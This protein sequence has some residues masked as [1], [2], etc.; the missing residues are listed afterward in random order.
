MN[1]FVARGSRWLAAALL[2]AI[3]PVHAESLGAGTLTPASGALTFDVLN[4][5]V[6]LKPGPTS[7]SDA[8]GSAIMIHARGDDY[9]SDPA[10]NAGDRVICGV[11][12]K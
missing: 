3:L 7:L 12:M 4:R 2:S 10:G 9:K 5:D 6:T 11:I 8:D 1:R